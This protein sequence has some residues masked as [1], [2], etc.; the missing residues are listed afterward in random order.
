[1]QLTQSQTIH[2]DLESSRINNVSKKLNKTIDRLLSSSTTTLDS[3]SFE[4]PK[5]FSNEHKYIQST[6]DKIPYRNT[7]TTNGEID[8]NAKWNDKKSDSQDQNDAEC[9]VNEKNYLLSKDCDKLKEFI[10]KS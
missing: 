9:V 4:I 1:M 7:T 6:N 5:A 10:G 2:H 8:A 3:S